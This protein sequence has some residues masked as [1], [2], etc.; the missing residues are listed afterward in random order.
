MTPW[1]ILAGKEIR[2]I[3]AMLEEQWGYTGKLEYAFL[4]NQQDNLS[5]VTRDIAKVDWDKLHITAVGLYFGELKNGLRLSI[6]GA[7]LI[8]PHATKN[9]YDLTAEEAMLWI[10]GNDLPTKSTAKGYLLVKHGNDWMGCGAIKNGNLLNFVPKSRRL[11][12]NA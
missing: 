10:K 11:P 1:K 2:E 12:A 9:V 8:G 5:I 6:E 4:K 7:Q 3:H